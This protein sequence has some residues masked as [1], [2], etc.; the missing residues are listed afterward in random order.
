MRNFIRL[1]SF[2]ALLIF[3]LT[4]FSMISVNSNS[5]TLKSFYLEPADSLDLLIFGPSS[6]KSGILPSV[7]YEETGI[8]SYNLSYAEAPA[9]AQYYWLKESLK[10]Q[11]PKVIVFFARYLISNDAFDSLEHRYRQMIDP[12][13]WSKN[14]VKCVYDI[15]THSKEQTF[16]SYVFPILRFHDKG[17]FSEYST[18]DIITLFH[19]SRDIN[20]GSK[21]N[22]EYMTISKQIRP[23]EFDD[24]NHDPDF[25]INGYYLTLAIDLCKANNIDVILIDLPDTFTNRYSIHI[26]NEVKQY[27]EA[28]EVKYLDFRYD[29]NELLIGIDYES[30]FYDSGHLNI[31]G[32]S[33]ITKQLAR[34]LK[35]NYDIPDRQ[36]TDADTHWPEVVENYH[37]LMQEYRDNLLLAGVTNKDTA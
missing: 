22:Q 14:K 34:F 1:T 30:D 8:T 32:A 3:L 2:L 10:S 18:D 31:S 19:P 27:A 16:I 33:K 37:V 20:Q 13:H 21:G 26:H 35:E 17:L 9:A 24:I 7:L 5:N 15:T 29:K 4:F 36:I 6:T 11:V 28:H 12:M 23:D 25:S